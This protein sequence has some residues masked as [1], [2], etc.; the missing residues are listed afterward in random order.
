MGSAK[1]CMPHPV[2][3]LVLETVFLL[4]QTNI[5]AGGYR[6]GSYLD[7]VELNIEGEKGW[8]YGSPLPK[9]LAWLRG[10][11]VMSQFYITGKL[12][13]QCIN[14]HVIMNCLCY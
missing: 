11:T 10:V 12:H 1:A 7:S 2:S 5:V 14:G 13:H 4:F 3:L 9:P 6:G 8:M